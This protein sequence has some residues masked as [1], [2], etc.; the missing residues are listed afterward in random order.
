MHR[1]MGHGLGFHR[2]SFVSLVVLATV[3]RAALSVVATA[4]WGG[5]AVDGNGNVYYG[6]W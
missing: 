2:V 5:V 3:A 6:D 4:A 1:E